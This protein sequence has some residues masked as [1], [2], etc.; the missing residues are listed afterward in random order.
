MSDI[1]P[2]TPQ[3]V[4]HYLRRTHNSKTGPN[5]IPYAAYK[6]ISS[7]ASSIFSVSSQIVQAGSFFRYGFNDCEAMFPPK[8]S[9]PRD[10]KEV[11]RAPAQTR[12][13]KSKNHDSKI[14]S[15]ERNFALAK[16]IK[17]YA[18]SLQNGFIKVEI[19]YAM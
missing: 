17:E 8:G 16:N 1:P 13:L 14:L 19:F 15:G 2:T 11:I 12:P 4:A 18:S 10:S 6:A 5:G 9:Q 3:S 7:Y